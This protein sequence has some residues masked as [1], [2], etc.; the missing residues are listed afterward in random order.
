MDFMNYKKNLI[1]LFLIQPFKVQI[2]DQT[3]TFQH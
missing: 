3:N 2:S 1:L